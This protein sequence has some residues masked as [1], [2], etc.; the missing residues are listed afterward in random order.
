MKLEQHK[1]EPSTRSLLRFDEDEVIAA[2]KFYAKHCGYFV[3][4]D[5]KCVVWFP[6]DNRE[7]VV[8]VV[9]IEGTD[10]GIKKG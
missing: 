8:L 9:D 7:R 6:H 5:A 10:F 2:L 4:D 3:P 1:T